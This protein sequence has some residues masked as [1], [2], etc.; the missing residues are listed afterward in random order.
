MSNFFLSFADKRLA[1]SSKRILK[2]AKHL[3]F[4]DDCFVLDEDSLSKSFKDKFKEKMVVGSRGFGYWCWKPEVIKIA[5]NMLKDD[6][7]LLYADVGCHLNKRGL[8]RLKEYFEILKGSSKGIVAFQ[9][10]A[11]FPEISPLNYDGRELFDQPNY[12]WIK[13][14]LFD[15]FNVRSDNKFTHSQAI[16]A[17]VILIRKC[18]ESFF[19][20]EEWAKIIND[21]FSLLDNSDS[22]SPN[23]EGF[24]E[25]RHDQAIFSILCLKYN[26]KVLSAY[27]YWYPKKSTTMG[28]FTPDW[29][30]L[31]NFPILAK[32][33]KD[34]GFITNTLNNLS[35]LIN[36]FF[37]IIRQIKKTLIFRKDR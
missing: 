18:K 4:F 11:P 9:A 30:E 3:S 13:G 1:R 37:L 20:I 28:L 15:F 25:H 27:E 32:R 6:D 16:G 33:D 8:S 22:I 12:K 34:M 7:L 14:D 24:V 2:Q 31:K 23:F 21:N 29:D 10:I 36:S 35:L 5:L 26:V 17:G 19:L